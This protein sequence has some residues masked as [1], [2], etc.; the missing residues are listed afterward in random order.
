MSGAELGKTMTIQ[1]L[2]VWRLFSS[3]A[4]RQGGQSA[5]GDLPAKLAS[6]WPSF[7]LLEVRIIRSPP[8]LKSNSIFA[9]R[10]LFSSQT[11]A[12]RFRAGQVRTLT[13]HW[14]CRTAI[15]LPTP[16]STPPVSPRR[17]FRPILAGHLGTGSSSIQKLSRRTRNHR[18]AIESQYQGLSAAESSGV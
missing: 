13:A 17:H 18:P 15:S 14:N 11:I 9:A 12:R 2:L 7:L 5:S 10:T 4:S 1:D 16:L 8:M 3:S 6:L